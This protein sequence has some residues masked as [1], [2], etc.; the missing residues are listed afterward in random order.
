MSDVARTT[1][2]G[3]LVITAAK[4]WFLVTGAIVNLGL[5][6]FFDRHAGQGAASMGEFGLV[7]NLVSILNMVMIT[8]TLQAVSKIVS[9]VPAQ[10]GSVV[11]RAVRVQLLVG[12]PVALAFAL[13]APLTARA[14]EDASLAAPIRLSAGVVLMYSFY[15]IFVGY[16]NGTKRF[17][18]QAL[19]DIGFATIK[20]LLIMGAVLAGLGVT[21]AIGG[22]VATSVIMTAVAV[23]WVQRTAGRAGETAR[24]PEAEL[25]ARGGRG[26][27]GGY[28][29][30]IMAYTLFLNAIIRADLFLL[31]ALSSTA[32]E[33][34]GLEEEAFRQASSRL[35]GIY[36]GMANVARL[37][38]QAVIA[39]TFVVFPII[40]RATFEGDR[41]GARAYIRES[42]RYSTIFI[43]S[44]AAV[45]IADREALLRTLYPGEYG[46]GGEA[47]MWLALG[48]VGFALL[49]VAS[50]I[51]ISAGQPLLSLGIAAAT[52]ALAAG[53][54]AALIPAGPTDDS[55]MTR[56]GVAT[57]VA[58]GLGTLL[59]MGV[60]F[61]RFGAS[62]PALSL[63]RVGLAAAVVVLVAPR[64]P[65][66]R[67]AE[68]LPGGGLVALAIVGLKMALFVVV[69]YAL[70]VALRE[71]GP[72]DRE[73][74]RRVLRRRSR[75]QEA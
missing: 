55:M 21:G 59:A 60:L 50:T 48:M 25:G 17:T 44:L 20:T 32:F 4:A 10:A 8:G 29:L 15:A 27:I 67:L 51:L 62:L 13:T 47:L 24:A 74:L 40:S 1:G 68:V 37:P 69:F 34:L 63:L 73:R 31:K 28:M 75:S 19:L 57:C 6:W 36:T 53:L 56:A 23:L 22:F 49:Y 14:L 54:A 35:S 26:R 38:Y 46:A 39:I 33:T 43:V 58:T 72:Q 52:A 42:L 2:R 5:P 12:V 66:E 7:I 65:L 30:A 16:F 41:A 71:F 9:E 3:F 11:R 45:L 64:V 18:R 61:R 70:L